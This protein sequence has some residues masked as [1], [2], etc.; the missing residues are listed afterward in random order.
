[1]QEAATYFYPKF[2]RLE[3]HETGAVV[4]WIMKDSSE[5]FRYTGKIIISDIDKLVAVPLIVMFTLSNDSP[6]IHSSMRV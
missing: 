2:L 6:P 4:K 5:R 1:M 3:D